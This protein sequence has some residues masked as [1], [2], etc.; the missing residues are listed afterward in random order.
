[1]RISFIVYL[2]Y[3]SRNF[4]EERGREKQEDEKIHFL[5][6]MP[7]FSPISIIILNRCKFL[8]NTKIETYRYSIVILHAR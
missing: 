6:C 7:F 8:E 2:K 4:L 3:S 5:R 1:M